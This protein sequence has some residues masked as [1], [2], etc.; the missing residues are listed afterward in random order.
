MTR[1]VTTLHGFP[2]KSGHMDGIGSAV[3]FNNPQK[4]TLG[5]DGSLYVTD[6]GN[7]AV[8]RISPTGLVTTIGGEAG[9]KGTGEGIGN[10]A[11]FHEPKGITIDQNG[12]VFVSD[13]NNHR[14]AKGRKIE[15]GRI[16][17]TDKN[18]NFIANDATIDLGSH[19]SGDP[20]LQG[21]LTLHNAGSLPVQILSKKLLI[22]DPSG[23]TIDLEAIPTV[24]EPFSVVPVMISFTRQQIGNH[25]ARLVLLTDQPENQTID[26]HLTAESPN[27]PPTFTDFVWEVENSRS[28]RIDIPDILQSANDLDGDLMF[29]QLLANLSQNGAQVITRG[30]S[31]LYVPLPNQQGIDRVPIRISDPHGA[32]VDGEI[33]VWLYSGHQHDYLLDAPVNFSRSRNSHHLEM[34]VKP[35]ASFMIQSSQDLITWHDIG[36]RQSN[37]DGLLKYDRY[38]FSNPYM[39]TIPCPCES[40]IINPELIDPINFIPLPYPITIIPITQPLPPP[41][42]FYRV[43]TL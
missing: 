12:S 43:R 28:R 14:V 31:V 17:I 7:H 9:Y 2:Q 13:S 3:R 15:A 23:F 6:T 35:L 21:V 42:T 40:I 39:P 5:D 37:R 19:S 25:Q 18:G 8:R 32:F 26:L 30:F 33:T 4:I 16:L 1:R 24:L 10:R 11:H 29:F 41:K 36:Q 20:A 27:L 34:Q 22:L 38:F